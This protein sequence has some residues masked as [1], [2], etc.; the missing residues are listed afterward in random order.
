MKSWKWLI[1]IVT[2]TNNKL[3]LAYLECYYTGEVASNHL[4]RVIQTL[5]DHSCIGHWGEKAD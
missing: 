1:I 3:R 5:G 2:I 4:Q